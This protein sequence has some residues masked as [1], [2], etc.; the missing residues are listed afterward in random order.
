MPKISQT[1]NDGAKTKQENL[2]LLRQVDC[3]S[4]TV[5]GAGTTLQLFPAFF[6]RV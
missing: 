5:F 3:L 6:S 2:F 4:I 1:N